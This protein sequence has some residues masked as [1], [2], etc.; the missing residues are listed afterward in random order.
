MYGK[1]EGQFECKTQQLRTPLV[2]ILV[3]LWCMSNEDEDYWV[4]YIV[5][6]QYYNNIKWYVTEWLLTLLCHT[7][8]FVDTQC[9]AEKA[10]RHLNLPTLLT[11]KYNWNLSIYFTEETWRQTDIIASLYIHFMPLVVNLTNQSDNTVF[12][13]LPVVLL[14][15]LPSYNSRVTISVRRDFSLK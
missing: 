7:T 8:T 11:N 5:V 1:R 6:L 3:N 10:K 15:T 13:I 4:V 9:D 2:T 14:C 12:Q